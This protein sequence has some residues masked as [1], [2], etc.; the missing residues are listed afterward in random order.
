MPRAVRKSD[1]KLPPDPVTTSAPWAASAIGTRA[2]LDAM[3]NHDG[4]DVTLSCKGRVVDWH[5]A[6]AQV[7]G[8]LVIAHGAKGMSAEAARAVVTQ[9]RLTADDMEEKLL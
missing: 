4:A 3:R 5:S 8:T 2:M 6:V 7:S 1:A 9:L